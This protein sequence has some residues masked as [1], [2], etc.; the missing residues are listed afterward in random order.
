MLEASVISRSW[1]RALATLS[2]VILLSLAPLARAVGEES[3]NIAARGDQELLVGI[4]IV[5]GLPGTGDS[6][7]DPAVIDASIIGVLKRAGLE[8]WRDQIAPGRVAVVMLSAALPEAPGDGARIDVSISAI[9]DARSISGGKL[10]ITPL[11][12]AE[13]IVHAVGK[14]T[15]AAGRDSPGAV[16]RTG[17][18]AQGAIIDRQGAGDDYAALTP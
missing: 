16:L 8:P 11:R 15:I 5:V 6:T 9:G 18:L 1:P 2:A 10:L 17:E 12:D 3:V 7:I 4:G 14:G 13:G